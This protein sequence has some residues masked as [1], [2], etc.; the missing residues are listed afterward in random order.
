MIIALLAA[1]AEVP[2]PAPEPVQANVPAGAPPEAPVGEPAV[3][4]A[5]APVEPTGPRPTAADIGDAGGAGCTYTTDAGVEVLVDFG[6]Q[7]FLGVDGA[8]VML[9]P[10]DGFPREHYPGPDGWDV[11]VTD[12]GANTSACPQDEACEAWFTPVTLT[13]SGPSGT[14]TAAARRVCGS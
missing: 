14:L 3:E 5:T 12:I 11:R 2:S 13:I 10:H 6:D 9:A 8:T 1:C 7:V 4:P